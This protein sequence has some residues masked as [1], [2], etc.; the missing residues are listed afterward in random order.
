[1]AE[2]ISK[3]DENRITG[4]LAVTDDAA[5]DL[6][7]LLVDPSTGRLK[8]TGTV[9]TGAEYD[10]DD[11][12]G[13]TDTGLAILA[14]RDDILSTLTPIEGDYVRLRVDSKGALHSILAAGTATIGNVGLEAIA[15]IGSDTL[16]DS[17]GNNT[18]QVIKTSAGTLYGLEVS[19]PN[20]ADAFIQLFDLAT[21]SVTVGTTTPKI[22]F[23]VPAGDGTLDGAMDK[24]FP[25]PMKFTTAITYACTTTTTGNTDPTI[26]LIVNA[27]FK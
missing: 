24:M 16:F 21:G 18:A 26:G 7:R 9:T 12:S 19:N 3:R 23:F 10:V 14:I 27:Y 5:A 20:S 8:V 6:K 22:S 13:A 2:E 25:V 1:M 15:T 4:L 11:P 17:D